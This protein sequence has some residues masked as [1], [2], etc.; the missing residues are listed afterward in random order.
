MR[1]VLD[2][3]WPAFPET[4]HAFWVVLWLVLVSLLF[5][6]VLILTISR[7]G[8]SQPLRIC[9]VLSLL[10]HVLLA[11][12]AAT[13]RIA[14]ATAGEP[15]ADIEISFSDTTATTRPDQAKTPPEPWER[16]P[17]QPPQLVEPSTV[18][19]MTTPPPA[20]AVPD[21]NPALANDAHQPS[22]TDFAADLP[23]AAAIDAAEISVP[24][25]QA[26][27][28]AAQPVMTDTG[29]RRRHEPPDAARGQADATRPTPQLA[30]ADLPPLEAVLPD[31]S[32]GDL[33]ADGQLSAAPPATAAPDTDKPSAA[34]TTASDAA[35][36]PTSELT[37]SASS[38]STESRSETVTP[39]HSDVPD[40][41]RQRFGKNRAEN[42]RRKGGTRRSEDA[43]RAGLKWLAAAQHRDGRWDAS[44]WGAGADARLAQQQRQQAGAKADTGVTGLALLAFLGAGHTHTHAGP[45]RDTVR[46]GLE[47]L[48]S[49]QA[50]DGN[51]A[52]SAR[53][54]A[55]MYCH[56]MATFAISEAYA[57]TADDRLESVVRSAVG[58]TLNVQH[59]TTGGWR[60]RRG[61][62]GDTSQLGWQVMA[63]KSAEVGGITIPDGTWYA[64]GRYLSRVSSGD[65]GGLAA[66]REGQG[67]SRA[68]TAEALVCRQ[69]LG[70]ST[71]DQTAN[72]AVRFILGELPVSDRQGGGR[73]N[74][75]YWYYAALALYQRQDEAWDRW[76]TAMQNALVETQVPAGQY[77][78]SWS[79]DT[80]WGGY[81]GRVYTTAMATLCLEV[82]YRYLPLYESL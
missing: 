45:Y 21:R 71:R 56:G 75:Y 26:Q 19:R 42:A 35:H 62:L 16:M 70:S 34:E 78:G 76:N 37:G 48:I 53:L 40:V 5:T 14:A 38:S 17:S 2:A 12:Y 28:D 68:M 54:F 61:D 59:P 31:V 81:G 52:G 4:I 65:Y 3:L 60:Y 74:F 33:T 10:A 43:V 55:A 1:N 82:Y 80:R 13:V 8:R 50:A 36:P 63:L 32:A 57:I 44:Q 46:R 73:M 39:P 77:A 23:S 22:P 69:L 72:E 47:Y 67:P 11:G 30:Q 58:Y 20:P 49:Q 51:L 41:Y 66:Y 24:Q 25:P 15:T 29:A 7:W 79:P 18:E 27:P 6:S 64:V 9:V